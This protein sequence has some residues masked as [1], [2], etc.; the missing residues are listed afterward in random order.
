MKSKIVRLFI[1]ALSAVSLL[2]AV[3]GCKDT[4]S[5]GKIPMGDNYNIEEGKIKMHTVKINGGKA[6]FDSCDTLYGIFFE[7]INHAAD[8]GLNPE[9]I[10]NRS[11]ES[12]A[13]NTQDCGSTAKWS[14]EGNGTARLRNFGSMY[15]TN[16]H[17]LHVVVD[18][19]GFSAYNEGYMG[20]PA[21]KGET[22]S[23]Y[24][25]V[26]NTDYNGEFE[27]SIVDKDGKLL[28]EKVVAVAG[29]TA[30]NGWTKYSADLM[31]TATENGRFKLTMNGTGV[32]EVDFISLMPTDT[33]K[34]NDE[35][36]WPYG[37][38]RK[39][40]VEALQ[41]IS[42]KFIRFPGGCI[43]EGNGFAN[44]YCW[45]DTIGPLEQRKEKYNLWF[46]R[47]EN[48]PYWQSYGVGYHEYFQLCEDL[49][50][51][52]LPI[53]N[54]ALS[55]Q[56]R[57][58]QFY[59]PDTDEFKREVQDALDLIE[60]ANG[61]ID[62]EWGAKRAANGHPEPFN[63]KYLGIGNEN[64]PNLDAGIDFWSNF[65][66]FYKAVKEVYPDITVV[67]TAGAN[68]YDSAFTEAW[69]RANSD[70]T[71]TYVDE[72]FYM[73]PDWFLTQAGRYD[74][75]DRSGAKVFAGEYAA[76][77]S[78]EAQT[79]DRDGTPNTLF[80]AVAEAVFLTGVE[81]NNDVVA[82][83]S[84]APLFGKVGQFQWSPN[85]I[86]FDNYDVCLTP[87]YY[88]QQ[89]FSTN[90][91]DETLEFTM[92]EPDSEM[93]TVKCG[94]VALGAWDTQVEYDNIR[95]TDA[96][97]KVIF[98]DDFSNGLDSCWKI[99]GGDWAVEDEVLKQTARYAQ[100]ALIYLDID[101]DF[102]GCTVTLD[103]KKTGGN[104]GFL[105]GY[106]YR[107]DKNYTWYNIGGWGNT[108]DRVERSIGGSK[109]SIAN[110]GSFEATELGKTYSFEITYGVDKA[111]IKK[112]GRVEQSYDIP[113]ANTQAYVY[114]SVTR[115]SKTGEIYLKIVNPDDA[116][117]KIKIDIRNL[118]GDVEGV[119][120]IQLADND[121]YIQNSVEHPDNIMPKT[122]EL[123]PKNLEHYTVPPYSVT[124]LRI[125][126][127][128]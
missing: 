46:E 49:G 47:C 23:F 84:Y 97:G 27:I 89:L 12:A 125:K 9:L 32:L 127:A 68:V 85:L 64:W 36:K 105:I 51:E 73:H 33:W 11:F 87:N 53:V 45:K 104:E 99:V 30:D 20:V 62:T 103:A 126:T 5:D 1:C 79:L 7:D 107:D 35:S 128:D 117:K 24:M 25:W 83:A 110:N 15:E 94:T 3:S 21:K 92:L 59:T 100:P 98:E 26:K 86:W 43:V 114:C 60:Y 90:Y 121:R 37:G 2:T 8:G 74:N 58:A 123:S 66:A 31:C 102:E 50:A 67:T 116:D 19:A 78:G 29:E 95:I 119:T 124:V 56:F 65:D 18:E 106:D 113:A 109:Q 81:R 77:Q 91:G 6:K 16:P 82:M 69:E 52:P 17:H 120:E 122:S 55:C 115:D 14:F 118:V 10:N 111:D 72:H 54:C 71:D 42:P 70:Y 22:Y 44:R 88:V 4:A 75:Y 57:W 80:S 40:L 101:A 108:A 48:D 41:G 34:G 112:N 76:H 39:D 28:T 96:K 13:T 61:D 38:M 93:K 63:L